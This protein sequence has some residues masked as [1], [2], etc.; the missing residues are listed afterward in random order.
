MRWFKEPLTVGPL[1]GAVL[2]LEK[3][4][5]ML[6]IYYQKRGWNKN[7]VPTKATLEKLGLTDVANQLAM[8]YQT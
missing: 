1:K 7:G 2:E 6:D 8:S 4:N 3:Y 5:T